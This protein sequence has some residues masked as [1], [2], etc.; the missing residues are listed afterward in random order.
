MSAA[1]LALFGLSG[2]ATIT[3]GTKDAFVVETDPSG[4]Q[5]STSIGHSCAATPCTMKIPRRSDFTVTIS[6][7]G[8]E[9]WSGQVTNQISGQG[10]LGMAGNV[11]FGGLIG[12]GVDLGTGAM[13]DLTPNPLVVRLETK[14]SAPALAR[15]SPPA[16]APLAAPLAPPVVAPPPAFVAAAPTVLP[17]PIPPAALAAQPP[18]RIAPGPILVQ[19]PPA[20]PA[21]APTPIAVRPP[22]PIYNPALAAPAAAQPASR[23]Y[24]ESR[25]VLPPLAYAGYPAQSLLQTGDIP[26]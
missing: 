18:V 20:L 17:A 2:C 15:T 4:A 24:A 14:G 23:A 7:E 13:H 8:Y 6:K 22:A 26:R 25:S 19:A 21:P 3:R 11:V 16:P 1:A 10:G 12:A 9:P 5:V